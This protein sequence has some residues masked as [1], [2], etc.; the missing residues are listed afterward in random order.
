[1]PMHVQNRYAEQLLGNAPR[2]P[3]FVTHYAADEDQQV[4]F[5]PLCLRIDGTHFVTLRLESHIH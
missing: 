2:M 1:M 5:A 3:E 4:R